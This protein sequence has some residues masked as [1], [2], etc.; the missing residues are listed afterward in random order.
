MDTLHSSVSK[1]E[2]EIARI[3]KWVYRYHNNCRTQRKP[4]AWREKGNPPLSEVLCF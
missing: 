4:P 2:D 1:N 3:I